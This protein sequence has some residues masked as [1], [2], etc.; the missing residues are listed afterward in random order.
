VWETTLH[1]KNKYLAEQRDICY[2]SP[3]KVDTFLDFATF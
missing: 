2:N 3:S 1:Y